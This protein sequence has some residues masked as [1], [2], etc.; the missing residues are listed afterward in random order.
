MSNPIEPLPS[1]PNGHAGG[2]IASEELVGHGH[3]VTHFDEP[4]LD[5]SV[6]ETKITETL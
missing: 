2:D 4:S 5:Y 3:F 6:S 1:T